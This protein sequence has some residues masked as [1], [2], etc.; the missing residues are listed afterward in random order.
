MEALAARSQEVIEVRPGRPLRGFFKA[1]GIS[2]VAITDLRS[3]E[4]LA[5]RRAAA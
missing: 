2:V 3:A 1:I 4:R 5:T